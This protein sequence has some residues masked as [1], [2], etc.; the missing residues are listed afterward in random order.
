MKDTP[1]TKLEMPSWTKA[2]K[3]VVTDPTISMKERNKWDKTIAKYA[4]QLEDKL[5]MVRLCAT[6]LENIAIKMGYQGH[7]MALRLKHI[8]AELRESPHGG[9]QY[10][11]FEESAQ[12]EKE[13]GE[14]E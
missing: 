4:D 2:A 14:L 11:S 12:L 9:S 8:A 7:P 1:I 6:E 10:L 5:Q 3:M 13:I